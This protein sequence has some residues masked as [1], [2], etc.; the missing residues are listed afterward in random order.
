MAIN[1]YKRGKTGSSGGFTAA[2]ILFLFA[3]VADMRF[4]GI[5]ELPDFISQFCGIYHKELVIVFLLLTFFAILVVCKGRFYMSLAQLALLAVFLCLIGIAAMGTVITYPTVSAVSVL[6]ECDYLLVLPGYLLL[7]C[8]FRQRGS[9]VKVLDAILFLAAICYVCSIAQ[10]VVYGATGSI[11]FPSMIT[12]GHIEVRGG[13]L[14]MTSQPPTAT[15]MIAY[16]FVRMV[17]GDER[18]KKRLFYIVC[19]ALGVWAIVGVVQTRMEVI[20]WIVAI[21]ATLLLTRMGKMSTFKKALVFAI[22]AALVLSSGYLDTLLGSFASD[23]QYGGDTA[24]VR[25]YAMAYYMN[26]F[27]NNPLFGFGF[28]NNDLYPSLTN[29]AGGL[30][31]T[32]DVGFVGQLAT[33]GLCFAVVYICFFGRLLYLAA[34]SWQSTDNEQ[35]AL[36]VIFIAYL[37]MTSATLIFMSPARIFQGVIVMS[38]F[39]YC[40]YLAVGRTALNETR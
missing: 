10:S 3:V 14:R 11:L 24:T 18:L 5:F 31:Y 2:E 22:L 40:G 21:V 16:S 19:F 20:A 32:S 38:F 36:M 27:L 39:E 29:G 35:H 4:F 33:W 25:Q 30:F 12:R 9:V 8:V 34:R 28:L 26:V 17:W 1:R 37:L 15:L 7:A 6:R 13:A 23:A